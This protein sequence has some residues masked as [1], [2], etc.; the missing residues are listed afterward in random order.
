M[1]EW[2]DNLN[3]EFEDTDFD[4]LGEERY[5]YISFV[6]AIT[7]MHQQT[8]RHYEKIGLIKPKRSRGN[9]RLY[10]IRDLKRM[11]LIRR[12]SKDMGINL[13]GIEVILNLLDQIR[14]MKRRY[15]DELGKL[16]MELRRYK[17]LFGDLIEDEPS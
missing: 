5:F 10:S 8:I 17:A 1:E 9:R 6:S 4:N 16:R 12:L 15:E 7:D 14:E 11:M 13:A 3:E 2:M